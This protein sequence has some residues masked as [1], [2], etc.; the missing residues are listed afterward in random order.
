MYLFQ[1]EN[2]RTSDRIIV[3][4]SSNERYYMQLFPVSANTVIR[5]LQAAKLLY[6]T[7]RGEADIFK[8]ESGCNSL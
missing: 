5:Y 8:E 7:D 2:I 6:N 3:S 4:K 1:S